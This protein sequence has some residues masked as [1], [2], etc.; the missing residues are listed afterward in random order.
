MNPKAQYKKELTE[1]INAHG[2]QVV[3]DALGVTLRSIQNYVSETKSLTPHESTIRKIHEVFA[4]HGSGLPLANGKE[5]PVL[6]GNEKIISLL[7]KH[8]SVLERQIDEKDRLIEDKAEHIKAL[9]YELNSA[10]EELKRQQ[11][12]LMIQ[13]KLNRGYGKGILSV[14]EVV[15][16][17]QEPK[18]SPEKIRSDVDKMVVEAMRGAS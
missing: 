7:E 10:V 12:E 15:L 4:K 11:T 3:A 6:E 5:A 18:K 9:R 13:T 2:A 17:N 16:H 8:I 14:L 1:L